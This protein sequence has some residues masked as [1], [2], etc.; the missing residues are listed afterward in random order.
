[1]SLRRLWAITR[2]EF[3]HVAR[4]WRT[5]FLVTFSPALL[6]FTLSYIFSFDVEQ[7]GVAVMD[8]DR[9]PTSRRYL[10]SLTADGDFV[11]AARP[12][13]YAEVDELIL[14][15]RVALA[16]VIPPGFGNAVQGGHPAPLQAIFDG[17]D[18]ITASQT[19]GQLNARSMAFVRTWS[20]R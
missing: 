16:L 6:L 4:D 1:M 20:P 9:S 2:K 7:A 15:G 14:S 8:L 12:V 19:L 13:G 17:V 10:E 11:I 5:L 3:R 18:P